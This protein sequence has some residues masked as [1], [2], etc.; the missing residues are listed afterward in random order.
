MSQWHIPFLDP[1]L[2]S[3]HPYP[4]L[5]LPCYPSPASSW[6]RSGLSKRRHRCVSRGGGG[7]VSRF[8]C[9]WRFARRFWRYRGG[10]VGLPWRRECVSMRA[11]HVAMGD[12][13]ILKRRGAKYNH[14]LKHHGSARGRS[15]LA[16]GRVIGSGPWKHTFFN[17]FF[18]AVSSLPAFAACR[19]SCFAV[20]CGPCRSQWL[21]DI[22]IYRSFY[23]EIKESFLEAGH[24][25]REG[26]EIYERVSQ[27]EV[28]ALVIFQ[29]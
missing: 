2:S 4:W 24:V 7:W 15:E 10:I 20:N 18:S 11:E 6:P 22:R 9:G 23:L 26:S 17:L 16:Q 8:A 14:K 12:R 1:S 28:E 27:Q 5:R 13:T 25:P 19:F 21:W 3:P 29:V